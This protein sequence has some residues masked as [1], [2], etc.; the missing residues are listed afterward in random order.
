MK[1]S[2]MEKVWVTEECIGCGT[3]E[4]MCPNVFVMTDDI[5]IVVENADLSDEDAIVE[6]A[7]ACPVE[8]IEYE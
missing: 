8:A 6:A 2:A 4:E 3:C 7:E 5:A 1:E